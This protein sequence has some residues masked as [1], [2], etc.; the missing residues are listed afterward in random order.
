MPR[1]YE[2][3]EESAFKPTAGG[4]V[5]QPPTLTWPFGRGPAYLVNEAQKAALAAC[6]R[7]QRLQTLLAMMAFMLI[8]LGS[9]VLI[10]V[11]GAV[12]RLS[13]AGFAASFIVILVVAMAIAL[14]P[15][16]FAVRAMRPLLAEAPRTD[17]RITTGEQ[18]QRLAGAISPKLLWLGGAGGIMMI[19]G[20]LMS[21][22]ATVAE[23][24]SVFRFPWQILTLVFGALLTSYFVYLGRLRRKARRSA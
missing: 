20:S 4:Y 1:W 6:L 5:F 21:I 8:A 15:Y 10:A 14:L 18:L 24:H 3:A 22:A 17:E 7:R 13:P 23:G 2:G 9:G 19:V 16:F 12:A 11:T